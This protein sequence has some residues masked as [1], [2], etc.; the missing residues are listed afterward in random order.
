[1]VIKVACFRAAAFSCFSICHLPRAAPLTQR[2]PRRAGS[3]QRLCELPTHR[4]DRSYKYNLALCLHVAACTLS[5]HR[6]D[7]LTLFTSPE[8]SDGIRTIASLSRPANGRRIPRPPISLLQ[9]SISGSI[10]ILSPFLFFFP[11][12]P[13]MAACGFWW[14]KEITVI[15]MLSD[16]SAPVNIRQEG[17]TPSSAVP[18]EREIKN[19]DK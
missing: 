6:P 19:K 10:K 2:S 11:L 5:T 15:Q 4:S 9:S 14:R 12:L 16:F 13:F 8:G 17:I 18:A 3:L 7:A 1:M